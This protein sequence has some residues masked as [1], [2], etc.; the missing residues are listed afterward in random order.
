MIIF[1]F[2]RCLI[3]VSTKIG[4]QY[5]TFFVASGLTLFLEVVSSYECIFL[6]I[7]RTAKMMNSDINRYRNSAKVMLVLVVSSSSSDFR[8]LSTKYGI[9]SSFRWENCWSSARS[10]PTLAECAIESPILSSGVGCDVRRQLR[11]RRSSLGRCQNS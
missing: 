8:C 3:D 10:S 9:S 4:G 2:S 11:D 1:N 5:N 7:R 6:K